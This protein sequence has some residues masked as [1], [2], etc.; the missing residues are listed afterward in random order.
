MD[1]PWLQLYPAAKKAIDTMVD[2]LGIVWQVFRRVYHYPLD[3]P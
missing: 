1:L 3:P 2:G